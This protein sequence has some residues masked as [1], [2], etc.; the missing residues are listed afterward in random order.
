M[1]VPTT[2]LEALRRGFQDYQ[3]LAL[4]AQAYQQ[5]LAPRERYEAIRARV[6]R[7]T[8]HLAKNPFPGSMAELEALRLEIGE[9]LDQTG[10]KVTK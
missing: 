1:P 2:R 6:D 8:E 4:F 3:Y 5:G 10:A 9:L 7:L